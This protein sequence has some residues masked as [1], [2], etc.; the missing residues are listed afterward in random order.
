MGNKRSCLCGC[1]SE[2]Q[3][4]CL[5]TGS[6][7]FYDDERKKPE[8]TK[9]WID[10]KAKEMLCAVWGLADAKEFIRSFIGDY[11][12]IIEGIVKEAGGEVVEK[13]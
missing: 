3:Q 7:C 1:W 12:G 13:K 5:Y 11:R 4:E 9:E 2:V 6:G 8:I 10:E